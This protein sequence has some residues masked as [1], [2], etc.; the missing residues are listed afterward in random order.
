MGLVYRKIIIYSYL[1]IHRKQSAKLRGLEDR[2]LRRHN[3]AVSESLEHRVKG[4]FPDARPI[5]V[6]G[7]ARSGTSIV[8]DAHKGKIQ[9]Q[10]LNKQVKA[11][12][13]KHTL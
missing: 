8:C 9:R 2:E 5:F 1:R 13:R 10:K 7:A 6:V 4:M 11:K 3:L 12:Q